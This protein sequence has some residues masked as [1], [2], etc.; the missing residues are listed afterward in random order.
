MGRLRNF[1]DKDIDQE[2]PDRAN[3]EDVTPL[4]VAERTTIVFNDALFSSFTSLGVNMDH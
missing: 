1:H 2:Y 3:D 4:G